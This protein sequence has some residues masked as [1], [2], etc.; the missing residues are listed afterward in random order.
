LP[1]WKTA[2]NKSEQSNSCAAGDCQ[3]LQTSLFCVDFMA[4]VLLE[5]AIVGVVRN[6]LSG[7]VG[8]VEGEQVGAQSH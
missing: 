8:E 3:L 4:V 5:V 2:Y 1:T 6:C 7:C